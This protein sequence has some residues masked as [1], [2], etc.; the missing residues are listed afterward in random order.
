[1]EQQN[2]TQ[3]LVPT[4]ADQWQ[5]AIQVEGTDLPLPSGNVARVRQ[6]APAAFLA[7]GMIPNPLLSIIRK[8][9]QE[10]SGMS[11]KAM[12]AITEDNSLLVSALE[13]FDRVLAHVM[14]QPQVKMPPP[15]R[16][17]GEYANKPQHDSGVKGY[18]Q[19]NEG[20]REAGVLYA[21]VVQMEDKMFIFQWCVGG[22]KDLESF[23]A[24]FQGRVGDLSDG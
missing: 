7:S 4:P 24:E 14:V 16:V 3:P 11:P 8:S 2:P 6:I 15:C 23:R 12:K 18:H 13:L 21:D 22:T 9:I 5:G 17:C 19:Y 1:M 20:D 10:K